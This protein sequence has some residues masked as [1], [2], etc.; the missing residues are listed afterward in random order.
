MPEEA[1]YNIELSKDRNSVITDLV[2]HL[3]ELVGAINRLRM[4]VVCVV[5][6]NI[7][8]CGATVVYLVLT[9]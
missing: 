6:G 8:I 3:D 4:S 9:R 5:G 7:L 2:V 1:I